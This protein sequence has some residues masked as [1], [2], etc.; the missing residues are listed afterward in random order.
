M[1]HEAQAG[2]G[3]GWRGASFSQAGC[4][5]SLTVQPTARMVNC[6]TLDRFTV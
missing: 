3:K 6:S 5:R 1:I 2:A 4:G